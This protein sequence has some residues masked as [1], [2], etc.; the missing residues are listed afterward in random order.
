M[1]LF[2]TLSRSQASMG[3]SASGTNT[4]I[5]SGCLTASDCSISY[6]SYRTLATFLQL[7]PS[8]SA[9]K[10]SKNAPIRRYRISYARPQETRGL[11][12]SRPQC[13]NSARQ[14]I[15]WSLVRPTQRTPLR[16]PRRCRHP[17][18]NFLPPSQPHRA[19]HRRRH[20]LVRIPRALARQCPPRRNRSQGRRVHM[21]RPFRRAEKD[22]MSEMQ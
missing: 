22:A 9:S 17:H 7:I 16:G 18:P 19:R 15:P 3:R 2:R 20:P 10:H 8:L 4:K 11:P 13:P 21:S 6:S 14:R 5:P 1:P 12:P